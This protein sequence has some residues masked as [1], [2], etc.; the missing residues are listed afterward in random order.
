MTSPEFQLTTDTNIINLTNT[1]SQTFLN[2]GNPNG[3]CS[4]NGIILDLS[5]YMAAPYSVAD[6]N[7]VTS[8]VN[9]FSDLLTGGQLSS[10][11]KTQIINYITGSTTTGTVTKPNFDPAAPTNVRDRVRSIVHLIMIS[12]EYA[13]Q[14]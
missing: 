4:F 9:T 1:L 10:A 7:G 13:V 3:L 2:T 14:R 8:L 11:T 5:P 6:V 12:P